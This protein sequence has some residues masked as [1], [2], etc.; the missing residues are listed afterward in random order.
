MDKVWYYRISNKVHGPCAHQ[1][2][3]DLIRKG[4]VQTHDEVAS[5]SKGPWKKV[6]QAE[7]FHF[8]GLDVS[9]EFKKK[10]S[11]HHHYVRE[12]DKTHVV[13]CPWRRFFA[14]FF[15]YAFF[16]LL[17]IILGR[18]TPIKVVS[19]HPYFLM[20]MLFVWVFIEAVLLK[21]IGTTPG[22]WLLSIQV[23]SRSGQYLSFRDSLHRSLSVWWL[24]LAAG[25]PF[26]CLVTMI[27][28]S[29][30]LSMLGVSSWDRFEGYRVSWKK[31]SATKVLIYLLVLA[32][33]GFFI[34]LNVNYVLSFF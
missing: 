21:V 22:K 33:Y 20:T 6:S 1:E 18:F 25:I 27:V 8:E 9:S 29:V 31:L 5:N 16:M 30:K 19:L 10:Q 28:A 12:T 7:E 34:S 13:S 24:G 23:L 11:S 3:F 14:R 4:E 2:L 32:S 17:L 15:D 26:V